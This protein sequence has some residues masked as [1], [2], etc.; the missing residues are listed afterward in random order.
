MKF[1]KLVDSAL[2]GLDN[3][4]YQLETMGI[5]DRVNRHTVIAYAMAEQYHLQ[6][7]LD[8]L[9]ARVGHYQLQAERTVGFFEKLAR[10]SVDLALKPARFSFDTVRGL[11]RQD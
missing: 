4:G 10:D 2:E 9:K 5:S 7:E 11:L 1:D 8:S 3:L 6:G